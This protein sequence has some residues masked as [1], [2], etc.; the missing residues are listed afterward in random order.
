MPRE[1]ACVPDTAT[2]FC[3]GRFGRAATEPGLLVTELTDFELASVQARAGQAA[4]AAAAIRQSFGV[5]LP[6]APRIVAGND[7]S[8]VWSGPDHWLALSRPAATGIEARLAASLQGL[9]AVCDQ[10]DSRIM[11]EVRGAKLREVLAKGVSLDLHPRAFSMGAAA[12][13]SVSH[14]SLQFW[15]TEDAPAFRLLVA[16]SYFQ[17]F[18]RWLAASAAEY[19]VEV[20]QPRAY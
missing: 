13:T 19:G 3:P 18:W 4:N 10:S 8:F 14:V 15:Q 12:L 9:A 7:M 20:R 1:P 5:C 6:D 11:L 16:R 17:S 2:Q